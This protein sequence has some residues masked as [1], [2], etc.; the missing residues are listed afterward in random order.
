M[1]S[2]DAVTPEFEHVNPKAL[3]MVHE[4][5]RAKAKPNLSPNKTEQDLRY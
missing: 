2:S 3:A 1:L 4:L 5:G